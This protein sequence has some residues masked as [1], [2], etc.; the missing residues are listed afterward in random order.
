MEHVLRYIEDTAAQVCGI[1]F[2]L[3]I[4]IQFS[5]WQEAGKSKEVCSRLMNK[6]QHLII[7]YQEGDI[8]NWYEKLYIH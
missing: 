1:S 2:W 6:Y 3:N 4:K 5:S 8:W 7:Y